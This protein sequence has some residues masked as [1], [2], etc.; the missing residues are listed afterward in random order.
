M[1]KQS[2][3][4]S[5]AQQKG[6]VLVTSLLLLI[7]VTLLAVGMFRSFGLDEKIAGNV[8]EKHRALNAAETAEQYAEYWL[9]T[10]GGTPITCAAPFVSI[11]PGQVCTNLLANPAQIP[12]TAGVNYIPTVTS[13]M[14]VTGVNGGQ[15]AYYNNPAFYIAYLGVSP[16][17]LG[18]IYQ[19]DAV[20][21]GGSVDTAA[22][23]E[24][25]YIVQSST[26]DLG[27]L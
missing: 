4:S 17:G 22:V 20:G 10:V 27:A 16:S 8:R 9:A 1:I 12:W 6:M 5:M 25:T 3:Q 11:N 7:V 15:G 19:I 26:K 14:N 24:A 2:T 18:S 23:V 13:A 21:Y